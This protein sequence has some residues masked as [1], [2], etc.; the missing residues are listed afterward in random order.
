[1]K[2]EET[3]DK[4]LQLRQTP[5]HTQRS[6]QWY[7]FKARETGEVKDNGRHRNTVV[8]GGLYMFHYDPKHKETL[9]YYDTF[10][11]IFPLQP[12]DDG[13]LGLNMHYLHPRLR[14]RLFDELYKYKNNDKMDKTTKLQISY[15]IL[16]GASKSK[17][18][19]P[20]LKRYLSKHVRSS[21][22][23][24]D[25]ND[26]NHAVFLPLQ[27]FKKK[28]ASQVWDESARKIRKYNGS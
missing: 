4:S 3:L 27:D 5:L 25:P 13:F 2:F 11:V 18:F 16:K 23:Y 20:C 1:M 19:M 17:L 26:W 7:R 22:L 15:Q 24:I 8:P 10:P 12:T 21:F 14:A 6:R 9:P 28:T